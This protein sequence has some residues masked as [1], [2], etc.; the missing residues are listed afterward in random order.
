MIF[1]SVESNYLELLKELLALGV[2][3]DIKNEV[4]VAYILCKMN[5]VITADRIKP[6]LFG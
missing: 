3:M 5:S 2:D 6:R 1:T 4:G